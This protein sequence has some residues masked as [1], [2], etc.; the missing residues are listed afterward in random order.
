MGGS[1]PG[2]LPREA[3]TGTTWAGRRRERGP[4]TRGCVCSVPTAPGPSAS[5]PLVLAPPATS[6]LQAAASRRTH[7]PCL[8]AVK[9]PPTLHLRWPVQPRGHGEKDG[10]VLPRPLSFG[11]PLWTSA[12]EAT[13]HGDRCPCGRSRGLT[14]TAR[15][16]RKHS[17]PVGCPGTPLLRSRE[18]A[19]AI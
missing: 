15:G 12:I 17:C 16:P 10:H 9:S 8:L 6:S 3:D 14:P 1:W 4:L 19:C 18:A 11:V 7:D 2:G 5:A 13:A